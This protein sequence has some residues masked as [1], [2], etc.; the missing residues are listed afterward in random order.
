MS[1]LGEFLSKTLPKKEPLVDGLI[2]RRDNCTLGGRRRH[3]KTT[4]VSNLV[5]ALTLPRPDFLGYAIPDARRVA[6]FYLED[7]PSELQEKLGLQ[8][9]SGDTADRLHLFSRE[10]VFA[11]GARTSVGDEKF[12]IYVIEKCAKARPDLIVFDN[13]SHLLEG[14]Y[15]N[16]RRVHA[17]V[18]FVYEL[19]QQFDAAVLFLA[20]PRKQ[21]AEF[22]VRLT[23]DPEQFFEEVL[24]TSHTI[25]S[26]GTLW[27]L[28]RNDE[29]TYFVGGAQRYTGTQGATALELNKDTGWFEA[30]DN[31]TL[32]LPL[33][34]N[35]EKRRNAW[36]AFPGSFTYSEARNAAKP[37]LKSE[38][39]FT[40]FWTELKRKNLMISSN[41]EHYQKADKESRGT[42]LGRCEVQNE[43]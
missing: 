40:P 30:Q 41:G 6:I 17:L 14:D 24:G 39:S 21:N 1:T 33:V 18:M 7:D 2:Y 9:S 26:T 5:L 29:I 42:G 19:N 4:L 25:N 22:K 34:V 28:Q 43:K 37:Y 11:A 16:P 13:L 10:D 31:F 23:D 38:G 8:R 15:N 36:A 32:N 20:H 3:G 27:G 35:T 12:R